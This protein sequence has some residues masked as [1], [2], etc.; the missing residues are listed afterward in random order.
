MKTKITLFAFVLNL[1]C[2]SIHAQTS[3]WVGP[4]TGDWGTASNWSPAMPIATD[5]VS[6][7][8]TFTVT[9]STNV[10]TINRLSVSGK[11][12]IAAS[13]SLSIEQTASTNTGAIVNLIGGQIENQGTL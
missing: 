5:S 7:P 11:L 3:T 1:L 10:G 2:I 12:I 9:A 6:I 4:A 13:G 8:A